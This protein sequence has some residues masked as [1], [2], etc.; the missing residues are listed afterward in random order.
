MQASHDA[1]R[2]K[3]ENFKCP[4]GN[5]GVVSENYKIGDQEYSK[6]A[7]GNYESKASWVIRKARIG[8]I[9]KI[10]GIVVCVCDKKD[11]KNKPIAGWTDVRFKLYFYDQF[12]DAFDIPHEFPG[13]QEFYGSAQFDEIG[14]WGKNWSQT[15]TF[16]W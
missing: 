16:S 4:Q 8:I 2:Q 7:T 12:A 5:I 1:I 3:I 6:L 13:S 15:G 11:G 10:S 14:A 9:K